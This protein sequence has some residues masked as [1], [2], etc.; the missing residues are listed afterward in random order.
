MFVVTNQALLFIGKD[1]EKF[2]VSNGFMG[3]VP[4]WVSKTRQFAHLV[5]DGKIV[6]SQGTSDKELEK[7]SK[8]NKNSKKSGKETPQNSEKI[9]EEPNSAEA[10]SENPKE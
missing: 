2:R 7:A 6:I 10:S 5:S 8:K 3:S 9:E 4:E 1:G